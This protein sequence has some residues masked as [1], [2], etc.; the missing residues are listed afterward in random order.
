MLFNM[1]LPGAVGEE[2]FAFEYSGNFTDNRDADGKGTVRF[3]TSGT[4]EVLSGKATVQAYILGGG[5]G[6]SF[7]NAEIGKNQYL[8]A[9]GGGGGGNQTVEVELT[10]GAY[11]IVMGTGGNAA[12]SSYLPEIIASTGGNTTAFGVT[13][14]G[15]T[16]G[17]IAGNMS[18]V[19]GGIGGTP[20]GSNGPTGNST[21]IDGGS[22]NGGG[23]VNGVPE[24]GGDGYVELTFS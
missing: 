13:S 7:M 22:P 6:G 24:N 2:P 3:N 17:H 4:L 14:T 18:T 5:G 12:S 23:V 21:E 9:A 15:G 10:P 19:T 8:T 16:G 1:I 11:D 20:N